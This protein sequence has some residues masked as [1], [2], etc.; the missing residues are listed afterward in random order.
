MSSLEKICAAIQE[1]PKGETCTHTELLLAEGVRIIRKPGTSEK[2]DIELT[3]IAHGI[4]VQ[5]IAGLDCVC[6]HARLLR[7]AAAC[8]VLEKMLEERKV[9]AKRLARLSDAIEAK[10]TGTVRITGATFRRY[11]SESYGN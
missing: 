5:E 6:S 2:L 10:A 4:E 3:A 9:A 8:S 1:S 7:E 11:R